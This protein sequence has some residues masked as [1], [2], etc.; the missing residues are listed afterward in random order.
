MMD[1]ASNVGSATVALFQPLMKAKP[2]PDQ[3]CQSGRGI[4]GLGSRYGTARL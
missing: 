3:C 1:E 4:I 2:H